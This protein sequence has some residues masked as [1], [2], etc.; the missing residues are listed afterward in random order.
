MSFQLKDKTDQKRTYEVEL[1]TSDFEDRGFQTSDIKI[2]LP[3][4]TTTG[5]QWIFDG[6]RMLHY[7]TIYKYKTELD[8]KGDSE[9]VNMH[10]NLSG[11]MSLQLSGAIKKFELGNN[12]HNIFYGKEAGGKLAIEDLNTRIFMIQLSK[13]AFFGIAENG[14]DSVR[15]FADAVAAEKPAAF[16]ETNLNI[17][18]AIHKC[19][20]NIL[21]CPYNERLKRMFFYSKAIELLVLQAE[22]LDRSASGNTSV[23]RSEQEKE[24]ILFARDYL[25]KKMDVPPTL[26]E[27]SKVA[28]INE[29]KLKKGFKEIFNQTAFQYLTDIR[30]D[31][32][33]D[34]LLTGKK[35]V[36]EIA[37]E[38][39]Y[40]SVQHFST[41]FKRKF[42]VSPG[43]GRK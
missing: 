16:S 41:A 40:S 30:L 17:D 8:W 18:V 9:M 32:A 33:K 31:K 6:M 39:G 14:N 35:P 29:F 34:D 12:Q 10:F 13:D 38:L 20:Q 28:G 23:L 15:R 3:F 24:Q 5:T 7:E 25:L 21:H 2:S 1:N 22:A 4:A 43:K 42:G 11:K 26:T 36:K 27:L 19:I 37:F